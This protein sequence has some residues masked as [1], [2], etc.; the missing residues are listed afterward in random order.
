MA[1]EG[2]EKEKKGDWSQEF[3]GIKVDF[4]LSSSSSL[5]D[6]KSLIIISIYLYTFKYQLY[7]NY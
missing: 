3:I 6:C 1:S 2:P 7:V 5:H 4:L